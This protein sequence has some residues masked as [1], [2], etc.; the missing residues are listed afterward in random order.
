MSIYPDKKLNKIKESIE[1]IEDKI[2]QEKMYKLFEEGKDF[3][4]EL[5]GRIKARKN[6]KENENGEIR[7]SKKNKNK[8]NV[9][10]ETNKK[11]SKN[12]LNIKTETTQS[13]IKYLSFDKNKMVAIIQHFR[14]IKLTQT[15]KYFTKQVETK[16]QVKTENKEPCED[17]RFIYY[18]K[19]LKL[20]LNYTNRDQT[21]RYI[22]DKSKALRERCLRNEAENLGKK[23]YSFIKTDSKIEIKS[24]SDDKESICTLQKI[25]SMQY[26]TI[27][28]YDRGEFEYAAY[29]FGEDLAQI[30]KYLDMPMQSVILIYYTSHFHFKITDSLCEIVVVREWCEEDIETFAECYKKYG[31]KIDNYFLHSF[32]DFKNERDLNIFFYYYNNKIINQTWDKKDRGLFQNLLYIFNKDWEMYTENGV[33]IINYEQVEADKHVGNFETRALYLEKPEVK[34]NYETINKDISEIKSYYNNYYKKLSDD[35]LLHDHEKYKYAMDKDLMNEIFVRY[36]KLERK[37]KRKKFE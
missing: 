11:D 4:K 33:K 36:Q 15:E 37:K 30:S 3:D 16:T 6:K 23:T 35:E 34:L 2:K 20:F 18:L 29:K 31:R 12:D 25:D 14:D 22:L 26:Y 17:N 1:K 27:C 24:I 10:E 8:Q 28:D 9:P 32:K 21:K 19:K 13:N 7:K 5:F